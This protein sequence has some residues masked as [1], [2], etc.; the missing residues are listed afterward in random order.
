[1]GRLAEPADVAGP[2][3]FLASD[4]ARFVSGQILFVDGGYTAG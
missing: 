4:A 3:V 1:M 2:L